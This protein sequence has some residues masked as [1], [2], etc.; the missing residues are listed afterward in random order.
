MHCLLQSKEEKK[1]LQETKPLLLGQF[2]YNFIFA[3]A[4]IEIPYVPYSQITKN[5][6]TYIV[7]V[8]HIKTLSCLSYPTHDTTQVLARKIQKHYCKCCQV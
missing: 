2:R 7:W 3:Q 4:P 1:S 8:I 5:K 6:L